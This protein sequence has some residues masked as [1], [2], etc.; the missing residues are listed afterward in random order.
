M[1][2]KQTYDHITN[3]PKIDYMPVSPYDLRMHI[4]F[5]ITRGLFYTL[6][7]KFLKNGTKVCF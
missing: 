5:E 3:L 7:D 2:G 4:V 6:K 1:F